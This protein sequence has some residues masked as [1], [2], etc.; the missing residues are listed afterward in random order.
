MNPIQRRHAHKLAQKSAH[1]SDLSRF[2][3]YEQQRLQLLQHRQQLSEVKS[4]Q[5][6]AQLKAEILPL[7]EDWLNG[8]LASRPH[9]HDV[10]FTTCMV[11]HI[12][13]GNLD[14]GTELGLFA[15]DHDM[16]MSDQYERNLATVLIDELTYGLRHDARLSVGHVHTLSERLIAKTDHGQHA[17]NVPD[18][19]RGKFFKQ[20]GLQ[21]SDDH[22]EQALNCLRLAQQYHAE[23]HVA[24]R[25]KALEKTL[26]EAATV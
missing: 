22:P 19:V 13:A 15:L 12:D 1:S 10:V 2:S 24:N 16:T 23:V 8:V 20:C 5:D 17:L 3:G 21:L 6:K 18:Q 9:P 11:W 26:S 4:R 25:I 7:Y 14:K